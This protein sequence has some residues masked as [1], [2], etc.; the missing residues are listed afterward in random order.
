MLRWFVAFAI[1]SIVVVLVAAARASAR[2]D[3]PA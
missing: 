2:V 3:V 1:P